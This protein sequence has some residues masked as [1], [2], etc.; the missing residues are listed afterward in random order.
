VAGADSLCAVIDHILL[1]VI[2]AIREALEGALLEQ[3]AVEERFQVD[4][5]LGDVTFETSFSLPGDQN[6]PRLRAD[7]VL[8][9]PTWSH[10]SFQA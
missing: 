5:F 8:D 10:S 7:L 1:D 9:S 2:G 3:Q 4:V 6:T